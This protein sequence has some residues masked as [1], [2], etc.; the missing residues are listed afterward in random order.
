M[1]DSNKAQKEFW[2]GAASAGWVAGQEN[3][4]RSLAAVTKLLMDTAQLTSG[5][6]VLDIGCGTGETSLLA[7]EKVGNAGSVLGVDIS[8][9]MLSHAKTRAADKK[10]ENVTF[11][12]GDAQSDGFPHEFDLVLSRF[13]VMFFEDSVAA[14]SNVRRHMASGGRICFACWRSPKLNDWVSLPVS[15]ARRHVSD[16]TPGDPL[17]PG[18]FAFADDARIQSILEGSGW[19]H[20]ECRAADFEMPWGNS[21]ENAADGLL[22]RGPIRALI[23]DQPQ[24]VIDKIRAEI[25]DA[26][27]PGD[28]PISLKGAVWIVTA[29]AD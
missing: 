14:F 22:E 26:L 10:L 12:L 1:S 24:E 6:R 4:D 25:V 16:D 3:L 29:Q 23:A 11:Q 27:P 20:V 18:P 9:P 21:R 19:K 13:G 8:D 15:I 7:A 28:G 5:E 2:N 17:A